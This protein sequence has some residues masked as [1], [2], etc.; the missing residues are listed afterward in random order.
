[1]Y[2]EERFYDDNGKKVMARTSKLRD[3]FH[4][5]RGFL[6]YYNGHTVNGLADIS[7][8]EAMSKTDI[9][10]IAILSRKLVVHS[11]FLG[12]RSG[13]VLKPMGIK[14]IAKVIGTE[15]RQT[16]R[17]IKKMTETG[18]IAKVTI[19][20]EGSKRN[21]YLVNPLY[22]MNGRNINDLLYWAFQEQLDYYMPEWAKERYGERKRSDE[23]EDTKAKGAATT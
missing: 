13:G 7:F 14:Q 1:M 15:E 20:T 6:M 19:D 23:D 8:P 10:N 5:E 11:N 22:F 12:Y 3:K 17:F 16:H 21:L 9:A 4:E 2:K 18:I